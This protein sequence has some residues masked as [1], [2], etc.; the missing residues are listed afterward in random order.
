MEKG[1]SSWP[2]SDAWRLVLSWVVHGPVLTKA[3]ACT[4]LKL[5]VPRSRHLACQSKAHLMKHGFLML[6][7]EA[8]ST[9]RH[10]FY[11]FALK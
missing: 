9:A 3:H 6:F 7:E 2:Q 5:K 1:S 11:L 8:Q 10:T 4:C